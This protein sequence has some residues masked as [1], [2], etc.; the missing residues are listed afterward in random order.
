MMDGPM[1]RPHAL[2]AANTHL[3]IPQPSPAVAV[4]RTGCRLHAKSAAWDL[5]KLKA[6]T[7]GAII[8]SCRKGSGLALLCNPLALPSLSLGHFWP[9]RHGSGIFGLGLQIVPQY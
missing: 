8:I 9:H 6:L 7:Q 4:L 3:G 1:T 2:L 5:S